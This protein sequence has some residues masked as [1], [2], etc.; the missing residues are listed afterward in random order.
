VKFTGWVARLFGI[1]EKKIES[2]EDLRLRLQKAYAA[3]RTITKIS[4]RMKARPERMA[5]YQKQRA[6]ALKRARIQQHKS[7]GLVDDQE[8][9]PQYPRMTLLEAK[10]KF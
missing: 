8:F 10:V 3:K 9:G 5:A 2:S 1:A 6:R 7:M 4:E